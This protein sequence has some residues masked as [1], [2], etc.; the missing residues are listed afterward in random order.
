MVM[1]CLKRIKIQSFF[2][3]PNRHNDEKS[4]FRKNLK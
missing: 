4:I 2:T 1:K 3:L